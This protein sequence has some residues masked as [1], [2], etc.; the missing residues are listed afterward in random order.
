MWGMAER[1][2]GSV[3]CKR[4][5]QAAAS[6]TRASNC[7]PRSSSGSKSPTTVG[8]ANHSWPV[9]RAGV[10]TFITTRASNFYLADSVN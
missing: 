6:G 2:R 1:I 5:F 7:A 3:E 9:D 4:T 8:A 10:D